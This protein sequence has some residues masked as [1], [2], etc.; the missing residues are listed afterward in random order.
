MTQDKN[1]PAD[2]PYVDTTPAW[3]TGPTDV[4][5]AGSDPDSRLRELKGQMAR[6]EST[7]DS[8]AVDRL[9]KEIT[10]VRQEHPATAKTPQQRAAEARR[11][12][13]QG[14]PDARTRAPQGRT[15]SPA[16][17]TPTGGSSGAAPS[18]TGG[19]SATGSGGSS[20]SGAT[21]KSGTGAGDK[22]VGKDK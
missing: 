4:P 13:A 14:D 1:K 22:P 8:S 21:G 10:K 11:E 6:A 2:Q 19:S 7:G 20:G 18:T 15:A 16:G 3:A 9:R 5:A 12:A 17:R